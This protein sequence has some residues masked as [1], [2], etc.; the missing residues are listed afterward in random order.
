MLTDKEALEATVKKQ[1]ELI[2]KQSHELKLAKA[3]LEV[4]ESS[5]EKAKY[6]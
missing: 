3:Q 4:K 6:V 5:I 2:D 1:H